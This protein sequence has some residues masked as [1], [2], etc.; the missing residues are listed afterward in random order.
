MSVPL[1]K[2]SE[3]EIN[4]LKG[5]GLSD[6]SARIYVAA[7]ELGEASVQ[8]LADK[9]GVARTSV[10]HII[11]ELIKKNFIIEVRKTKKTLYLPVAPKDIYL[12][13]R[14]K[15]REFELL[16]PFI[17][18]RM[19]S[20]HTRSKVV[21]FHGVTGFKQAWDLIFSSRTKE[22]AMITQGK[23]FLEFVKEKYIL[24]EIIQ[25]KIKLG[26]RSRQL[27]TDNQYTR[28]FVTKDKKENRETRFLPQGTDISFTEII[29]EEYVFFISNRIE[30]MIFA[31]EH[32][33][34]AYTRR[35]LFEVLWKCC[36]R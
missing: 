31:V 4:S 28:G 7:V 3:S 2:L 14:E 12:Q 30:N 10:Y 25:R 11:E 16:A 6:K 35:E 5:I 22:Y 21:F 33:G 13:T 27:V 19:T 17:E 9:S 24:D 36:G 15:L 29:C 26:F 20:V 18:E 23:H 8:E 32:D 1:T 34:Y